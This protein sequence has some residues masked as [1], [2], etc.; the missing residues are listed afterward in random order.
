M[1]KLKDGSIEVEVLKPADIEKIR[2][3]SRSKDKGPWVD[4]WEEMA[5]KSSIRRLSKRLPLNTD[6]DD[7]IRRDDSLYGRS[8][9]ADPCP[10]AWPCAQRA[11]IF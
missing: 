3:V 4:W 7:L 6:L 9:R 11:P 1:A 10:P 8:E 2:G 5:K